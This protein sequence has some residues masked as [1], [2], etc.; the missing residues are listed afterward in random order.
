VGL[1]AGL[2]TKVRGKIR[3]LYRGSNPDR[4]AVQSVV[5][6]YTDCA[7]PAPNNMGK[8]NG[9]QNTKNYLNIN[10]YIIVTL[11]IKL[12][13]GSVSIKTDSG[14]SDRSS[15]KGSEL[16]RVFRPKLKKK[17]LGYP[18]YFSMV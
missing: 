5:R 14:V 4:P 1:R 17:H 12:Y 15:C 16:I 7:T 11:N 2:D 3:F 10:E 13:F 9:I 6:H 8:C 18:L